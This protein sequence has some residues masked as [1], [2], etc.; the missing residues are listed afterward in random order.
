MNKLLASFALATTS[1]A[2]AQPAQETQYIR[3]ERMDRGDSLNLESKMVKDI[4]LLSPSKFYAVF[5]L[6]SG[7]PRAIECSMLQAGIIEVT[8]HLNREK[9]VQKSE[10]LQ[11][12]LTEMKNAAINCEG[13]MEINPF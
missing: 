3:F 1:L 11:Q 5:R 6:A 8:G 9:S 4:G 7:K 12:S 10:N 2:S 13:V